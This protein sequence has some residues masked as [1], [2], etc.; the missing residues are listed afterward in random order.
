MTR[1][2]DETFEAMA[3]E[4]ET[5]PDATSDRLLLLSEARR[6][7]ESEAVLEKRV[8]QLVALEM[9]A[10]KKVSDLRSQLAVYEQ[11]PP[12]M[13]DW[14]DL[15]VRTGTQVAMENV[16]KEMD[17]LRRDLNIKQEYIDE[18]ERGICL[19]IEA[20]ENA[21]YD[22]QD[23]DFDLHLPALKKLVDWY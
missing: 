19:L 21:E 20:A 8:G 23:F 6:A 3:G 16:K 4:Y 13:S 22:G 5:E 17:G 14:K 7:R 15:A 11:E 10:Q 12:T 9:E 2:T 18:L 1:M